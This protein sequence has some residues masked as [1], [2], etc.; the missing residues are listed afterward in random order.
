MCS[1]S[2][3]GVVALQLLSLL[4]LLLFGQHVSASGP[5]FA[6]PSFPRSLKDHQPPAGQQASALSHLGPKYPGSA[7]QQN[8]MPAGGRFLP[9]SGGRVYQ[10]PAGSAPIYRL[11]SEQH[12]QR[13]NP[14]NQ[15]GGTIVSSRGI[16]MVAAAMPPKLHRYEAK[17]SP[18]R[19]PLK[20]EK[21]PQALLRY[22]LKPAQSYEGLPQDLRGPKYEEAAILPRYDHQLRQRYWNPAQVLPMH[23]ANPAEVVASQWYK[24]EP[25]QTYEKPARS[26]KVPQALPRHNHPERLQ[27]YQQPL[28]SYEA[29]LPQKLMWPSYEA[30]LHPGLK[31]KVSPRGFQANVRASPF[32]RP[33]WQ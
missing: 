25:P 1:S 15:Q 32:G 10:G 13:R 6:P 19:S 7:S 30:K 11:D 16:Q 5:Y 9:S 20:Y 14:P 22:G 17:S 29:T 12:Q 18:V 27:V 2:P 21:P 23:Q 31:T 3:L 4:P 28:P 26:P 24:A 33:S 8:R